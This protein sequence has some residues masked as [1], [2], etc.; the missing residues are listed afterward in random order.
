MRIVVDLQA[1]QTESRLRGMGRYSLSLTLALARIARNHDLWIALN[2]RFEHTIGLLRGTFD[3]LV[4]QDHIRV[5]DIP[6]PVLA[7]NPANEWRIRA[8]ERVRESF[9]ASLRPDVIFFSGLFEGWISDA[10]TSVGTL[11]SVGL[12]A[13]IL[14]DLIPLVLKDHYLTDS[15]VREWYFR[16]LD[17]LKRTDLLFA[18]SEHSRQDAISAL[19]IPGKRVVNIRGA[20]DTHFR[21]LVLTP[22]EIRE[23]RE[24]FGLT[25]SFIMYTG[26]IDYRKNIE[27][28]IESYALCPKEIRETH[29][30]AIVCSIRDDDRQ[31]LQGVARRFG[32]RENDVILTGFVTDDEIVRLY[33]MCALYMFPSLYEGFG[34]P[35]LEAMSCGAPVIGSNVS[36]IPEVIGRADALFDP[37]RP[38]AIAQK[39]VHVLTDEG[40]LESLR[41]HSLEHSKKFSWEESARRVLDT[42]EDACAAHGKQPGGPHLGSRRRP[43]MAYISPLPPQRSGIADYSAELLPELSR[44]YEIEVVVHQQEVSD[45]WIEANFPIRSAAWFDRHSNRFDRVLYHIGN[46]TFHTYQFDLLEKH[47]GIVVLHD[48]FLSGVIHHLDHCGMRPGWFAKSLLLSHGYEAIRALSQDLE[49]AVWAYPANK[50]VLDHAHGVIVHSEL[51]KQ[52]AATFYGFNYSNNWRVIPQLRRVPP[53]MDRDAA[54]I[55]LGIRNDDF[56]VCSFGLLGPTK[57][58]HRLLEAWFESPLS[59]DERCQL[60]FVGQECVGPYGNELEAY[61]KSRGLNRRVK[62]TGWVSPEEYGCYLAAADMG[63]QLRTRSRGETSRSVLDCLASQLPVVFN[64]NGP[65]AEFPEDV[66]IRLSDA[67]SSEDLARALTRL[68]ESPEERTRLALAGVDHIQ[69]FHVPAVVG[70]FY[71]DAIES[72]AGEGHSA[73]SYADRNG[74]NSY[75]HLIDSIGRID[76]RI[77]PTEE[78]LIAVATSVARNSEQTDGRTRIFVDISSLVFDRITDRFVSEARSVVRRLLSLKHSLMQV[79]PVYVQGEVLRKASQYTCALAGV[80]CQGVEDECLV[81]TCSDTLVEMF[82]VDG[83]GPS[84]FLRR[85]VDCGADACIGR[86][87]RLVS[88]RD[89]PQKSGENEENVPQSEAEVKIETLFAEN[90]IQLERVGR[91]LR[92]EDVREVPLKGGSESPSDLA[93]HPSSSDLGTVPDQEG[94][95]GIQ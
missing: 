44:F 9:L 49:Q 31:L 51:V 23:V 56:V 90:G 60:V 76:C 15:R 47:R 36:S 72:L 18:I 84:A 25:R 63:V 65:A 66:G 34:L 32:L 61:I 8:A 80:N 5:F 85:A 42:L 30:L 48:F 11:E 93:D 92:P 70:E 43:R 88:R 74:R 21:R 89:G 59:R 14:Y 20:A 75:E 77:G 45:P 41:Q 27:G 79:I 12:S 4:P 19:H 55:K 86:P 95:Y 53:K 39:M 82:C 17:S 71:R 46:S 64:A 13:G 50:I 73:Y 22:D 29:Q 68:W 3:G 38:Q 28:L 94:T 10:V 67:F 91:A 87:V 1:A 35:P 6:G 16:K 33:N 58:N 54:R 62:I 37:S 26:G 81:L 52:W 24:K 57:L 2:G 40:F 83:H 7:E 69:H 78:D